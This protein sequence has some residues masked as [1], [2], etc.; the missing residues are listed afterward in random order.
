MSVKL[1][2][3][4]LSLVQVEDVQ[5]VA[6]SLSVLAGHEVCFLYNFDSVSRRAGWRCAAEK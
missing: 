5:G 1:H 4:T 6:P 3:E 2:T